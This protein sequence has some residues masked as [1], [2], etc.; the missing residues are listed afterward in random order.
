MEEK[1]KA[2]SPWLV[3]LN[4]ICSG[5][6]KWGVE[7]GQGAECPLPGQGSNK[8]SRESLSFQKPRCLRH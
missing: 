5:E 1:P 3:L 2:E 7:L 8:S 6:G 4:S